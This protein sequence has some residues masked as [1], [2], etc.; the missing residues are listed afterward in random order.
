MPR[1]ASVLLSLPSEVLSSSRSL[2]VSLSSSSISETAL[3][4]RRAVFAWTLVVLESADFS[5][6]VLVLDSTDFV[7]L[8]TTDFDGCCFL[9]SSRLRFAPVA[10]TE[11]EEEEEEVAFNEIGRVFVGWRCL[12]DTAIADAAALLHR[13][14]AGVCWLGCDNSVCG[15]SAR[16]KFVCASVSCME[17]KK[18]NQLKKD[19]MANKWV[20]Q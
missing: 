11:D 18:K 15:D 13:F 12:V 5:F 14:S 8:C 17:L 3:V 16:D 9:F 10:E 1:R 6:L 19:V 20:R 7:D 4:V 2:S